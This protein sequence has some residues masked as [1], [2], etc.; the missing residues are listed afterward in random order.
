MT[1]MATGTVWTLFGAEGRMLEA[2]IAAGGCEWM[3]LPR[4]MSLLRTAD[5]RVLRMVRD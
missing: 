3:G 2:G 1:G 5:G 4:G